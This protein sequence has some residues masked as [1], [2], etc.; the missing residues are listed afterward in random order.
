MATRRL[1]GVWRDSQVFRP[2]LRDERAGLVSAQRQ[3]KKQAVAPQPAHY[4]D[5]LQLDTIPIKYHG[6]RSRTKKRSVPAIRALSQP[7][8][9]GPT[10]PSPQTKMES[11]MECEAIKLREGTGRENRQGCEGE[12]GR[13]R[14]GGG[15]GSVDGG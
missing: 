8:Q 1:P 4:S 6:V 3:K 7:P 12:R 9:P 11:A 5:A 15:G 13:A 10:S 14:R 2:E